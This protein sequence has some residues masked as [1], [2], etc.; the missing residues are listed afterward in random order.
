[1]DRVGLEALDSPR[2]TGCEK[3]TL[4]LKCVAPDCCVCGIAA[5]CA[6]CLILSTGVQPSHPPR[7]ESLDRAT[8]TSPSPS[9]PYYP[10]PRSPN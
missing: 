5:A 4:Y 3:H 2:P 8:S 7:F 1:M 10:Q 9:L 6:F